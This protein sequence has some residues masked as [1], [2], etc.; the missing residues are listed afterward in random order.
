MVVASGS[1]GAGWLYCGWIGVGL[2]KMFIGVLSWASLC[3]GIG[4]C[5]KNGF[6]NEMSEISRSVHIPIMICMLWCTLSC[7]WL[8]DQILFGFNM[9]PDSDWNTLSPWD[10]EYFVILVMCL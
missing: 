1:F 7:W 5:K 10:C 3:W 4:K 2:T 6:R 9:I 8:T